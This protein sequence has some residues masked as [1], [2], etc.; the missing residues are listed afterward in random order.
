MNLLEAVAD[1]NLFADQFGGDSWANWRA[2]LGGFYGLPL[3]ETQAA[4]FHELTNRTPVLSPFGELWLAIGRRGGKSNAAGLLAVF[5]AFFND[6]RSKLAPGEVAT[7]IIVAADRKQARSVMR[8]IRGLIESCPMLQAMVVRDGQESIELVN[9]CVIEVMTATHRGIRG[10]TVCCAIL[11]EIAFWMVDGASPDREIINALR[12]SLATLNGKLIALSSPYARRGV[13]WESYRRHFGSDS[14]RVLVAQAPTLTMNPTLDESVVAEAYEN[15]PTAAAAEYGA[16]FRTDVEGYVT[17]ETLDRCT[18]PSQLE[19]MPDSRS[20]YTAFVDPSGGS[21]DAF[22]LAIAHQDKDERV[23][24]DCTRAVRPPFSPESVVD[25]FCKLL[26]TYRIRE[27]RG[28]AY[29][30]EWPREQFNKRRISYIRSDKNKSELYKDLLPLLNSGNIELP[31][32]NQLHRELLGLERRT[33]RGGRDSIDHAP[34]AHD[35]LANAIAGVANFTA[36]PKP[37]MS[38]NLGWAAIGPCTPY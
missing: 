6:Y 26:K 8:Y 11:D 18:R 25:E 4:V 9:R 38:I 29:A 36:K 32:D 16:Q 13:L 30:G 27:V 33:T 19:I 21:A 7:V 31:P 17:V 1:P 20:T 10:Y 22:T 37:A 5:E 34:G 15:D 35:D 23:I 28:D 14:A 2:L 3:D 24:I 12:P